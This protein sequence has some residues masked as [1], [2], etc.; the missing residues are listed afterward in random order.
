M[1]DEL[2]GIYK[3][4]DYAYCTCVSADYVVPTAT[5]L[6]NNNCLSCGKTYAE[7]E[8]EYT[9]KIQELNDRRAEEIK[10]LQDEEDEDKDDETD[11]GKR[12]ILPELDKID[13]NVSL[14]DLFRKD[15]FPSIIANEEPFANAEGDIGTFEDG[16]IVVNYWNKY[17]ELNRGDKQKINKL[18]REA[19]DTD[20]LIDVLTKFIKNGTIND[21]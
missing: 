2:A 17:K 7:L 1:V 19:P 18:V 20:D 14:M 9:K 4:G 3:K 12:P 21:A 8:I 15:V 5:D 11:S 10:K 13:K 16:Q 6:F